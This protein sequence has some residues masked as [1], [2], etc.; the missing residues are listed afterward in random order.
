MTTENDDYILFE[1]FDT[2]Q[3]PQYLWENENVLGEGTEQA[4][5]GEL[6]PEVLEETEPTYETETDSV[7]DYGEQ[8]EIS[9]YHTP[10]VASD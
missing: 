9:D 5:L 8:S 4:E 10:G 6:S 3:N 2:S 7:T 1:G